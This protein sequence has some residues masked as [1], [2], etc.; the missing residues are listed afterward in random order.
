MAISKNVIIVKYHSGFYGEWITLAN[1]T[2]TDINL[3]NWKM[4]EYL[5]TTSVG[6][7]WQFPS[8]T[9]IKAK[10]LLIVRRTNGS[11]ITGAPATVPVIQS[12]LG[13]FGRDGEKIV[14]LNPSNQQIDELIFRTGTTLYS[15]NT[16]FQIRASL[17]R[18][19]AFVRK[20]INDNDRVD[21]WEIV[22][23][24]TP[25]IRAWE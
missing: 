25:P 7:T 21:D 12:T 9:V 19:E 14:L 11:G 5:S 23:G 2:N 16:P 8:G 18:S 24:T 6:T 13:P 4:R 10:S 15:G 20:F 22:R 17:T 3:T 1:I